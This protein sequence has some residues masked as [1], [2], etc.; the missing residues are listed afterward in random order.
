MPQLGNR[1]GLAEEMLVLTLGSSTH[2]DSWRRMNIPDNIIPHYSHVSEELCIS[3]I[4][5]LWVLQDPLKEEWSEKTFVLPAGKHFDKFRTTDTDTGEIVYTPIYEHASQSGAVYFDL[6][7]D[8]VRNFNIEGITEE[9]MLCPSDSVS[10]GQVENV[11][12]L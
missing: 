2:Q 4:I 1:R 11:M 9:Y 8:S 10:A 3:G 5:A 12:F 7:N 6:K